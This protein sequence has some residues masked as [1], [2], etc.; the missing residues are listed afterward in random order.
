[1]KL[2][3]VFREFVTIVNYNLT[4][5]IGGKTGT[6]L[7]PNN[8]AMET[9]LQGLYNNNTQV[10][11]YKGSCD[12]YMYTLDKAWSFYVRGPGPVRDDMALFERSIFDALNSTCSIKGI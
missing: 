12:V 9:A 6:V 3:C 1:M 7:Q 4:I 2:I 11:I 8:M 5:D 10:N